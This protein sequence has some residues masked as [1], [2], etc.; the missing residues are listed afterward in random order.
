M[1]KSLP[2]DSFPVAVHCT[3]GWERQAREDAHVE[4]SFELT[5]EGLVS[6]QS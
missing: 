5:R 4:F 1:S 6:L 3:V 2:F